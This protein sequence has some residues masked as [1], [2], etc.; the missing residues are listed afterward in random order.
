MKKNQSLSPPPDLFEESLV[1]ARKES[2]IYMNQIRFGVASAFGALFLYGAL[3][4]HLQSYRETG[5]LVILY[6]IGAGLLWAGSRRSGRILTASRFA[7][8]LLDMPFATLIQW[9]RLGYEDADSN[10]A[11]FSLS[12]YLF[13]VLLSTFS[14]RVRQTVVCAVIGTVLFWILALASGLS[15]IS[16]ISA[17][18][19]L[20]MTAWMA[21][22]LPLR[23]TRLIREAAEKQ[24]RRDRLALYFSPGVAEMIEARDELGEGESCEISVLF[25]DIR[26]FTRMS[27]TMEARDVVKLLNEFHGRMVDAIFRHGG[28]LDKY[29]G[30]GL[31]AYFNAPVPQHD[32]AERSVRCALA[33][34]TELKMLNQ[35]REAR[36][37]PVIGLGIGI[38]AGYAVVGNIGAT[39]R[40]EFT[41]IGDT[42]NVAS[43]LQHMTRDHEGTDILVSDAV[44]EKCNAPGDLKFQEVAEVDVRGRDQRL[45]IFAPSVLSPEAESV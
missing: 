43:R 35:H 10:T 28:T 13:L 17:P 16:F 34:I 9:L 4:L 14:M 37:E 3:R 15:A 30:D 1:Q 25:C 24:S 42:V 33:M 2:A 41:A 21:S 29:L 7:V 6:W 23:Q 36:G 18:V 26:G 39:H 32:H 8:P 38:H 11:V 22:A 40:R 20:M 27:E 31:L 12:V 19:M 44:V 45:R 5:W